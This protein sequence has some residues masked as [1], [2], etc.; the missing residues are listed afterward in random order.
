M[1]HPQG[2]SITWFFVCLIEGR[3][4]KSPLYSHSIFIIY[5]YHNYFQR[6]HSLWLWLL[7]S[8]GFLFLSVWQSQP[9]ICQHLP[10][11][12]PESCEITASNLLWSH[13]LAHLMSTFLATTINWDSFYCLSPDSNSGQALFQ[14]LFTSTLN[15]LNNHSSDTIEVEK[16]WAILLSLLEPRHRT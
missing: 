10:F 14:G 7:L 11:L 12:I 2:K 1:I 8:F 15:L 6:F 3:V 13:C 16:S 4:F 9:N 5:K